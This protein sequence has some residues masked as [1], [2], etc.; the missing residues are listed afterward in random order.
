[1]AK[2]QGLLSSFGMSDEIG[3]GRRIR[4]LRTDAGWSQPAL[5]EALRDA[6]LNWGQSTLSK[7][8]AGERPLRL[9]EAHK[10]AS[11]LG[12]RDVSELFPPA[13]EWEALVGFFR[14][15]ARDLGQRAIL[16]RMEA[17]QAND[18]LEAVEGLRAAAA[19]ERVKFSGSGKDVAYHLLTSQLHTVLSL[20]RLLGATED[21]LQWI[22]DGSTPPGQ[23][24]LMNPPTEY[25]IMRFGELLPELLPDVEFGADD[26][27]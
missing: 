15:A 4:A 23:R 12:L 9:S 19:G 8:E 10:L 11:A 25:A 18:T 1:M 26:G 24:E 13:D 22:L 21:Q 17:D 3:I 6:G 5:I 27:S 20:A 7:V 2:A 14:L 16:A